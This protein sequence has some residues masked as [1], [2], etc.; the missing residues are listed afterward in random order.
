MISYTQRSDRAI[1]LATK[2]EKD[3]AQRGYSIWLDVNMTDKSEAA[4]KEAVENSMVVLALITGGTPNLDDENAYLKRPFCVNELKW[5][6]AARKHVQPVVRME[7]KSNIGKFIAMAPGELKCLGGIDFVDLTDKHYWKVGVDLILEKAKARGAFLPLSGGG[8]SRSLL[9]FS[10]SSHR[11]SRR[12][13]W[14]SVAPMPGE[15]NEVTE[16]T[17]RAPATARVDG[18]SDT[19]VENIDSAEDLASLKAPK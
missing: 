10:P 9:G 14:S 2:L 15:S 19:I 18:A 7:D 16:L 6:F 11:S 5:A 3:L 1:V 8:S 4:M 13:S 12:S 17:G